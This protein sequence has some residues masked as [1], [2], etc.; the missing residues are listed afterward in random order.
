VIRVLSY[1]V[2]KEL[3]DGRLV[4]LLER[5]QPEPLPVQLV[6]PRLSPPPPKVRAFIELAI[7]MLKAALQ[8]DHVPQHSR[9]L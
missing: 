1:Q 6:H 7:P 3:R 8:S 2:E 5:F 9:P 4:R